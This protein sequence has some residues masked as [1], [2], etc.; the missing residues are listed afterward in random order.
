MVLK[1]NVGAT[2]NQ[3]HDE[4]NLNNRRIHFGHLP[5]KI[6][7]KDIARVVS[8]SIVCCVCITKTLKI[9]LHISYSK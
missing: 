1:G 8:S 9:L 6:L 4:N 7:S 3:K 5:I 2:E